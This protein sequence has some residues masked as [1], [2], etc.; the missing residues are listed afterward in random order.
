MQVNKYYKYNNNYKDFHIPYYIKLLSIVDSSCL[1]KEIKDSEKNICTSSIEF[2][3][4]YF[5]LVT[6]LEVQLYYELS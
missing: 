6:E 5:T 4:R 1:F 3:T 2:F